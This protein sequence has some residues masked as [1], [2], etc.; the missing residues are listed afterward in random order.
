[1]GTGYRTEKNL[2]SDWYRVPTK[3]SIVLTPDI[4]YRVIFWN[5]IKY[6]IQID[7][8]FDVFKWR[9]INYKLVIFF[10]IRIRRSAKK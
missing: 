10:N 5:S 4:A 8:S 6:L 3:F 1:M 9:I 7:S 2:S